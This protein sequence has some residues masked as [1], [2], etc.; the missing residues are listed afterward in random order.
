MVLHSPCDTDAFI[1]DGRRFREGTLLPKKVSSLQRDLGEDS[2]GASVASEIGRLRQECGQS[3][4]ILLLLRDQCEFQRQLGSIAP[5]LLLVCDIHRLAEHVFCFRSAPQPH[6]GLALALVGHQR[7]LKFRYG[8]GELD[9]AVVVVEGLGRPTELNVAMAEQRHPANDRGNIAV[10]LGDLER[11]SE[12]NDRRADIALEKCD[13]T[14]L[15]ARAVGPRLFP[16]LLRYGERL[17]PRFLRE[18]RIEIRVRFAFDHQ[19]AQPKAVVGLKKWV[20]KVLGKPLR[21]LW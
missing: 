5:R 20:V 1:E 19:A 14:K 15:A 10:R 6:E 13:Q 8:T 9:C 16:E 4:N 7:K 17:T 11:L 21:N 12:L 3:I 2:T 18:N